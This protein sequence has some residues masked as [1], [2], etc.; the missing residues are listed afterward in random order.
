MNQHPSKPSQNLVRVRRFRKKAHQTRIEIL[1]DEELKAWFRSLPGKSN[2]NKMLALQEVWE[3]HQ[4]ECAQ[5]LPKPD[6]PDYEKLL[7]LRI[8]REQS[9]KFSRN[10]H[11]E[12]ER[13]WRKKWREDTHYRAAAERLVSHLQIPEL[14]DCIAQGW[15]PYLLEHELLAL[16]TA[17][18]LD[19]LHLVW[20]IWRGKHEFYD[21]VRPFA[22]HISFQLAEA[23][24]EEAHRQS[25]LIW[26]RNHPST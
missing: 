11:T 10:H 13:G 3:M 15:G 19:A 5:S 26:A 16:T 2:T 23:L 6:A 18:R 14:A 25:N 17:P 1:M 9:D 7:R 20:L 8:A 12:P 22:G 4:P 21:A 24:R